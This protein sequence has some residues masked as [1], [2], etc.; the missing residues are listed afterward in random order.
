MIDDAKIEQEKQFKR[1]IAEVK[2]KKP[3]LPE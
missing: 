1:M 3:E 2:T